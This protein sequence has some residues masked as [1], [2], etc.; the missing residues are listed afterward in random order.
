[1]LIFIL[2]PIYK[3]HMQ[4]QIKHQ[5][6]FFEIFP[7]TK[8]SHFLNYSTN[9]LG[10]KH[11][12]AEISSTLH[13]CHQTFTTG[14][15]VVVKTKCKDLMEDIEGAGNMLGADTIGTIALVYNF[16]WSFVPGKIPSFQHN[17]VAK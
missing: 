3:L 9:S 11:I 12:V 7:G 8:P 5:T 10:S 2:I 6:P 16:W 1:M 14:Y 17:F 13:I 15:H 4:S